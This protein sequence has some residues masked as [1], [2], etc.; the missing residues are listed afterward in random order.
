LVL[1]YYDDCSDTEI[2]QLLDCRVATV[3][4][5]IHR[6]LHRLRRAIES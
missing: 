3:R 5:L 2:A 1:R 4:R 6:G